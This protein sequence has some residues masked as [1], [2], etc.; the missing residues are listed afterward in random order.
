MDAN[1]Y[2]TKRNVQF[3]S[4]Y[5]MNF[6]AVFNRTGRLLVH[7]L[8]MCVY[9]YSINFFGWHKYFREP[10]IEISIEH[11]NTIIHNY[12]IHHL[13]F[14]LVI[15]STSTVETV[16]LYTEFSLYEGR[17]KSFAH[18]S[19]KWKGIGIFPQFF[20][21]NSRLKYDKANTKL[22]FHQRGL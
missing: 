14:M 21:Y 6:S 5:H 10:I 20:L 12:Y 13:Y 15:Y 18:M 19:L 8:Y 11:S 17:V 9:E 7:E 16:L 2:C 4:S 1:F 22:I 3:I